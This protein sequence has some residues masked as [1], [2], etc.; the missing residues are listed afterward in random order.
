VT[1]G[2]SRFDADTE[3]RDAGRLSWDAQVGDGWVSLSG[4]PNGGYLMGLALLAA[5]RA[6]PGIEPITATAHFLRPGQIGPARLTAKVVKRGRTYSTAVV[7]LE[8]D[9]KERVQTIVTMGGPGSTDEGVPLDFAPPAPAFP[10]PDECPPAGPDVV[11]SASVRQRFDYRL[12]PADGAQVHG[13][14]R[15]ADGRDPDLAAVPLVV[16]SFPP[17]VLGERPDVTMSTL[18]L[19]VHFRQPPE[20]GWLQARIGSRALLRGTVE[21][22]A[23]L[24]DSAGRLVAMSRQIAQ[25]RSPAARR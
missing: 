21:E 13:W 2:T 22:D 6:L 10:G 20:P 14:I 12:A 9:G 7:R 11:S 25:V 5:R 19:T 18:E 16:D 8:Q 3:L 4:V 23:E 15:F 17:A 1:T 24:W